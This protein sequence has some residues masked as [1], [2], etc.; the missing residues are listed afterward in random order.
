MNEQL[1]H[2]L[3]EGVRRFLLKPENAELLALCGELY[4]EA[5]RLL[6]FEPLPPEDRAQVANA[7][8]MICEEVV[9]EMDFWVWIGSS[10]RTGVDESDLP[11]I[12]IPAVAHA[13]YMQRVTE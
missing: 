12:I 8:E 11:R 9:E 3:T 4:T 1:N 5:V 13:L 6:D 2:A 10:N 7:Y